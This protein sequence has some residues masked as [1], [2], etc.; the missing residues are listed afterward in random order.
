MLLLTLVLALGACAL[1]TEAGPTVGGVSVEGA[2]GSARGATAPAAPTGAAPPEGST[3]PEQAPSTASPNVPVP[4]PVPAPA[5]A[6]TPSA[7]GSGAPGTG[8]P[9][10]VVAGD[11]EVHFLD[12]G[13]AD[14]TL[15]RHADV[16]L[17]VD[18]GSHRSD[19]VLRHLRRLGVTSLDVLVLTHP[20]ADHIG[21]ADRI[22]EAMPVGEVWWSGSVH[23]TQTFA[24]L[25]E[26]IEQTKVSVEQPR[27]GQQTQIGPL[28]IDV[29][30]PSA[31]VDLRDFHDASLALRLTFGDVAFVLTGDAER[32][33]ESRMVRGGR[34]DADVLKLGH[35]GSRTST[36]E[37][38]L[39]AVGPRF[40]IV[41]AGASNS[42]GHPHA[43][44]VDRVRSG[45]VD[46]FATPAHGTIV[47]RTDGQAVAVTTERSGAVVAGA[48]GST[49][50]TSPSTPGP[51][52]VSPGTGPL[53][54]SA[55]QVDVNAAG[56]ADLERIRHIGPARAADLV[57]LRPF[58]RLEDLQAINGIGAARLADIIEQ[59]VACVRVQ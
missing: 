23:T 47:V 20:H 26:A 4:V 21:Q 12:V 28:M 49:T 34:L 16:T 44:V 57:R 37:S 38:F 58:T 43:E 19:D 2:S 11:L 35:H 27:A 53:G 30:N 32:P 40:A 13:Q 33:A 42:Y 22:L 10:T 48:G 45:G 50:S 9:T 54:C 1:P 17:L 36:N 56:T 29:L 55:G 41:S 5:P 14:A 8:R 46:L 59:G 51:S 15:F 6:P 31:S 7:P 39:R 18:A 3:G 24:R 25:V 52:P